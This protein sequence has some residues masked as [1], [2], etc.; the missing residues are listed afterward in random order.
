MRRVPVASEKPGEENPLGLLH[1]S[2]AA[3]RPRKPGPRQLERMQAAFT[4]AIDS[5][6]R[7]LGATPTPDGFYVYRIDTK[8]GELRFSASPSSLG[9]GGQLVTRFEDVDRACALLNPRKFMQ[10]FSGLNPH[11]GK[12]NLILYDV[13]PADAYAR[14]LRHIE[15]VLER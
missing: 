2:E 13:G 10:H 4:E 11:S 9:P 12:W 14:A 7:E 5:V 3:M 6:A 8:A 15:S 1:E